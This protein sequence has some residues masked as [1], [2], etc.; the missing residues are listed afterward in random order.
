MLSFIVRGIVRDK[1]RSLLPIIVVSIG[2]FLTVVLSAWMRGIFGDMTNM[3][4]NF[5][6]G[7]VKVMTNAYAENKSQIPNDLAILGVEEFQ[8][9]FEADYP[10]IEWVSRIQF[11]ALLDVPDANG[12]TRA[13]GTMVGKAIDMLTPGSK[14]I[15]RMNLIKALS[16]D[17]GS[18]LPQQQGEVLISEDFA[19]RFNVKIGDDVTVFGSTMYGS[20][21]F[22]NYSVCG[23]I[24][25]GN[26]FLDRGALILDI[27]DARVAM[28]MDDATG[29]LLGYFKSGEYDDQ[30]AK[31]V[32]AHFNNKYSKTDDEY[33]PVMEILTDDSM[34]G[35]YLKMADNIGAMMVSILIVILSIVLW[36]T[37]LLGTIRRYSEFG[38]RMALGERKVHI[39][40]S[41]IGEAVVIGIIG[42]LVGTGLGL[43]LAYYLQE[44]GVDFSA[45]MTNVTMMLPSVYRAEIT[46]ETFYIG[47]IPGLF[48]MVLGNALAGRAIFKR[49]T[50]QL[51]KELEV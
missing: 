3:T 30:E 20:M 14:E 31:R 17:N 2:V 46:P 10:E 5:D 51:F 48:A 37:G 43:W 6:S 38:V 24:K 47:F 44:T 13:Q 25:F 45:L 39:Y 26:A 23:T 28:D 27:R 18:R 40:K 50:S 4:A 36:N 29:E 34:V 32:Q 33:S 12:E 22:T 1:N 7:H 8:R 49:Q 16:V 41:M 11:G 15:E 35:N 19:Q 9:Q 42:S 21:M